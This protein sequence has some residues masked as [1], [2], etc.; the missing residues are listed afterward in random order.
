MK[1]TEL[2]AANLGKRVESDKGIF[3]VALLAD[4]TG[5]LKNGEKNVPYVQLTS[6]GA[7]IDLHPEK[8]KQLF[9][10]G[11]FGALRIMADIA[12]EPVAP[13]A[14]EDY[15]VKSETAD[16][17][18]APF[19]TSIEDANKA[20]AANNS[21]PTTDAP[22]PAPKK[23]SKKEATLRIYKELNVDGKQRVAI[24]A[25]MRTELNMGV[26]GANTYYQNVHSGLWK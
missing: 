7:M 1:A 19:T 12:G 17:T 15:S 5:T 22:P 9:T 2:F 3:T 25:K 14:I 18:E 16:S 26:P 24:I 4:K 23:E 6:E 13:A 8:A 20:D 10:K 11:E 21:E